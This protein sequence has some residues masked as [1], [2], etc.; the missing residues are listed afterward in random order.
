MSSVQ[1]LVGKTLGKYKVLEHLGHG[2]MAEVYKGIQEQL[3]RLVAIKVLHPFLADEEGFVIRFQREARIVATLRHQNIVQVY[4]F[5]ENKELGI[6]YMV[7]EYI[8]GPT[9]KQRL[10]KGPLPPEEAARIG[11]A[12]ADALDYAHKRDMVHRDIK[13]ANIMFTSD[14]NPV[15][16]DFGIAKMMSLSGLTA[17]GA[18]VGTPA[19]MAPEVGMGRPGT[20]A[21]D[22]YSLGVVLYQ[23]VT[24]RLPFE[25]DSPMGMVMQHINDPPPPPSQF[26]PDIPPELE[27]IILHALEK[28]PEARFKSAGEM[29]AALRFVVQRLTVQ[30][31]A[32]APELP[33]PAPPP[34]TETEEEEEDE[35]ELL[36]RTWPTQAQRQTGT[37]PP[38]TPTGYTPTG[39]TPATPTTPADLRGG[40]EEEEETAFPEKPRPRPPFTRRLLRAAL[41]LAVLSVLITAAWLAM[42]R[43]LP[44]VQLSAIP[45]PFLQG[46]E[47][48]ASQPPTA[49]PTTSVPTATASPEPTETPAP[50]F[51][52]SPTFT[53]APTDTPSPTPIPLE[54]L[55]AFR[56]RQERVQVEP[57]GP[58]APGTALV[59]YIP[60]RNTGKCNWPDG[61]E[62]V[63]AQGETMG[64]ITPQP[65]EAI[66]PGEQTTIILPLQA[67]AEPGTYETRWEIRRQGEERTLGSPI[68][69]SIEVREDLPTPTPLPPAEGAEPTPSPQ[70]TVSDPE[71]LDWHEDVTQGKWYATVRFQASGGTGVYRYY[72][73]EVREE[74]L[75]EDG[76][77]SFEAPRC[78]GFP[79][80]ILVLSGEEVA[81]WTGTIPYPA[82]ERCR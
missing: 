39:Y 43:T 31:E 49:T 3:D 53:P 61:L 48:P 56:V 64:A 74:N 46:N 28:D 42:G 54:V 76:T 51:T 5:D 45:I 82:P 4:D 27:A 11:A 50:T 36:L 60:L 24:G 17:S 57:D 6:Y 35:D 62:L 29:A 19:Y 67:P 66:P 9:L 14:G 34:A 52:P 38:Y 63:L 7:M 16:T 26:V 13:P 18:M 59:A 10:S 65:I 41:T 25:S 40:L 37:Y 58:V 32:Q 1:F 79:M 69:L 77:F 15:L 73:S 47:M 55:C 75:S 44:T 23:M 21:S 8:D 72:L 30:E 71:L 78:T 2:G 68:I 22:I 81:R 33:P 80:T 70:L 12:I 20:V